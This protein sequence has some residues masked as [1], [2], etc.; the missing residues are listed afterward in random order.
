MKK[1]ILIL[2]LCWSA[3][4]VCARAQSFTTA[5]GYTAGSPSP[6]F[7]TAGGFT[8]SGLGVNSATGDVFYLESG[9]YGGTNDTRLFV[10]TMASGFATRTELFS[11]SAATGGQG[12]GIYGSFVRVSGSKVFFGENSTGTIRSVNLDGS[13]PSLLATVVG[14]YD[15]TFS[16]AAAF[17]SA[18]QNAYP[19]APANKVFKLNLSTGQLDTILDTGGDYSGA[20]AF[21]AAGD[22]L[23]GATT[24]GSI[25]SG[26]IYK[27]T[28]AQVASVTDANPLASD[29]ALTIGNGTRIYNNGSNGYLARVDDA[30]L[31]ALQSPF[32]SAATATRLDLANLAT[33]QL[34]GQTASGSFFGAADATSSAFYVAVTG[35]SVSGPTSVYR[36][37]P[38]PEPSACALAGIA[39]LVLGGRCL[40]SRKKR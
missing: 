33:T 6:L 4:L 16:G 35:D 37:A 3:L 1:L 14:N 39:A 18:N 15:L 11:Y 5:A 19:S 22:L 34:A 32:G 12:A 23:Y 36:I 40:S 9:N 13:A 25:S 28:A 17:L 38:V 27:F 31:F 29:T 7:S 24:F 30:H 10:N 8:I 21:D 26:G 2:A 20:I